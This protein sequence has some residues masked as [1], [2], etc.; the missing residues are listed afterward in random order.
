ME[1]LKNIGEQWLRGLWNWDPACLFAGVC[2]LLAGSLAT[3]IGTKLGAKGAFGAL[4]LVWRGARWLTR[5]KP[6]G[7]MAAKILDAMDR[8][9]PRLRPTDHDIVDYGAVVSI[10]TDW[11]CVEKFNVNKLLTLREKKTILGIA[12]ADRQALQAAMLHEKQQSQIRQ[13]LA[14]LTA[15]ETPSRDDQL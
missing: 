1:M 13:A 4:R 9:P 5:P 15:A 3:S 10:G 14:A 6:P 12:S 8:N 2:L 11:V 7:E